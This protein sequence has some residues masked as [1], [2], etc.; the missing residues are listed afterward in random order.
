M[1]W[2]TAFVD[3]APDEFD[4]GVEFWRGVTGYALSPL[5]GELDEFATLVPPVGAAHLRV[6]RLGVGPSRVHLDLHVTDPAAATDDAVALGATVVIRHPTYAILTSPGGF[7]FCFERQALSRP[8][9]PADWGS[10]LTSVVDQVCLDAPEPAYERELEFWR[11]LTGWEE[12]DVHAH[13]EFRRLIRPVDQP[14][15][16]L[17]QRLEEQTGPV[18]AHFD[19]AASDQQTEVE[20]HRALGAHVAWFGDGWVVMRPPVGPA[21]CITGRAPG[22]RVLDVPD[23]R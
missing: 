1:F 11:A 8:A 20:R 22:M 5:R 13:P 16:L 12:R 7:E 14:L 9:P 4:R 15:Q 23:S 6:P 3:L 18:R 17:F 19:L 21:Y 2:M 10:G